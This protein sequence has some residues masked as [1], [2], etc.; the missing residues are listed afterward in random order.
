M[1]TTGLFFICYTRLKGITKGGKLLVL[2]TL[3]GTPC[4]ALVMPVL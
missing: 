1:K 4:L 2:G 3:G